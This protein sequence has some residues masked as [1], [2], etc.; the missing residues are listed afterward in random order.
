MLATLAFATKAAAHFQ[1]L[2]NAV[3]DACAS[4]SQC[5]PSNDA[6]DEDV[7]D[8]DDDDYDVGMMMV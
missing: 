1:Q 6:E 7:D 4:A 2:S 3:G 8:D 5:P